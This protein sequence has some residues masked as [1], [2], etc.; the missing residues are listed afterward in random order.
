MNYKIIKV[1]DNKFIPLVKIGDS[2]RAIKSK[3]MFPKFFYTWD[4]EYGADHIKN[5][6]VKSSLKALKVIHAY[7]EREF[8]KKQATHS[9]ENGISLEVE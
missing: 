5:C 4:I 2:W 9:V 3:G 7:K 8:I 1:S 6:E